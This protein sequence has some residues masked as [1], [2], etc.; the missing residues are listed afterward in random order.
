[1]MILWMFLFIDFVFIDVTYTKE[2]LW[3]FTHLPIYIDDIEIFRIGMNI[4]LVTFLLFFILGIIERFDLESQTA[5]RLRWID[6][7]VFCSWIYLAW[8]IE[9]YVPL[10]FLLF[11]TACI[12]VGI[13]LH[14]KQLS[15]IGF[16]AP[17]QKRL[18]L[19]IVLG[20]L[21]YMPIVDG[22]G[23]E[24]T[25]ALGIDTYSEREEWL[26]ESLQ[27]LGKIGDEGKIASALLSFC[28]SWVAICLVGPIGEEIIFRGYLQTLF[29]R[30]VGKVWS[31]LITSIIFSLYHIDVPYFLVL[32]LMGIILSLVREIFN[33]VWAASALHI[34]GNTVS[35]MYDVFSW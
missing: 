15:V 33:S 35:C 16:Q 20:S 24:V 19:L 17:V 21:L 34:F 31:I 11:F 14:F 18:L 29:T 10:N 12:V 9:M 26:T 3:R 22:L 1:M 28:I 6:F 8:Y 5:H 13:C 25:T 32:F 2:H 30:H 4:G 27:L 7:A 23:F